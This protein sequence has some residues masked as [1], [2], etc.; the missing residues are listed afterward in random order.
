MPANPGRSPRRHLEWWLIVV[1]L[2]AAAMASFLLGFHGLIAPPPDK[3]RLYIVLAIAGLIGT[4]GAGLVGVGA[5]PGQPDARGVGLS[6]RAI[7][8]GA[9]LF[10]GAFALRWA[11]AVLEASPAFRAL[12]AQLWGLPDAALWLL[13]LAAYCMSGVTGLGGLAWFGA[14]AADHFCSEE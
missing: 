9:I 12:D 5:A 1:P 6:G 4:S 3:D 10:P 2:W 13:V 11:L 14:L 7:V 8:V